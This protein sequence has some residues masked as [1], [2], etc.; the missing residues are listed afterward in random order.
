MAENGE[1]KAM[2]HSAAMMEMET[3][4]KWSKS[5]YDSDGRFEARKFYPIEA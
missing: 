5:G 4:H 3:L 1:V 2:T